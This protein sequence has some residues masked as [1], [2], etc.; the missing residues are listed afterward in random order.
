MDRSVL[1]S[2]L[3]EFEKIAA[4]VLMRKLSPEAVA[5][6]KRMTGFGRQAKA[7]P[8]A[9]GYL[10]PAATRKSFAGTRKEVAQAT[11]KLPGL[12][13]IELRSLAARQ[14][15]MGR[16]QR[17]ESFLKRTGRASAPGV[18]GRLA[19]IGGHPRRITRTPARVVEQKKMLSKA[20]L[21]AEVPG[22]GG[23]GTSIGTAVPRSRR[24]TRQ[25]TVSAVM[26]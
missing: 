10:S 13:D 21:P 8:A 2:F 4:T 6:M 26:A 11:E 25:P 12:T 14:Q 23:A 17:L 15:A 7:A 1:A 9:K 3:G 18:E 5:L 20:T 19:T 22:L 16:R 24:L